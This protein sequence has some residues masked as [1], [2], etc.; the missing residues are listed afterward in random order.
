MKKIIVSEEQVSKLF[1][2]VNE[3]NVIDNDTDEYEQEDFNEQPT[4]DIAEEKVYE[5]TEG[6]LMSL[7]KESVQNILREEMSEFE[8][9][10]VSEVINDNISL[11]EIGEI[12]ESYLYDK[13]DNCVGRL[14]DLHFKYDTNENYILGSRPSM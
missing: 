4:N 14:K 9:I 5:M 11:S 2:P 1:R 13:N 6:E 10:P 8:D 7:V 12:L 3:D